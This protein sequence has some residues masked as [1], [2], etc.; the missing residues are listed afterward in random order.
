MDDDKYSPHPP[1]N[2]HYEFIE[3]VLIKASKVYLSMKS[4]NP[5]AKPAC[6]PP[7]R[8]SPDVPEKV[9]PSEKTDEKAFGR[10]MR[11]L[12]AVKLYELGRLS[13]G[14]AAELAGMPRVEFLLTLERYKAFP[15]EAE[16]RDLESVTA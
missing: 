1:N 14:R 7:S 2:P 15:L 4:R 11:I 5:H 13:S 3:I 12:A 6:A 16:L 9:L 8:A 10:E